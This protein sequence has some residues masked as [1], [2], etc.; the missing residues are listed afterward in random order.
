MWIT[1]TARH[2]ICSPHKIS[3]AGPGAQLAQALD[4]MPTCGLGPNSSEIARLLDRRLKTLAVDSRCSLCTIARSRTRQSDSGSCSSGHR[5]SS[6][7]QPVS[8]PGWGMQLKRGENFT[9]SRPRVAVASASV[10]STGRGFA[11][12]SHRTSSWGG[13][14]CM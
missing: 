2:L 3:G 1:Q 14:R 5:I 9:R 11:R 4:L 12:A 7:Q 13:M 8:Y 10:R 6:C